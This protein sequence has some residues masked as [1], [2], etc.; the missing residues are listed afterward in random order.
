[1]A[2]GQIGMTT[3]RPERQVAVLSLRQKL[4]PR[5]LLPQNVNELQSSA[6]LKTGPIP[7]ST[8]HCSSTVA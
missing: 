8:R 7:K 2:R 3:T 1:M 4:L 5:E 6:C